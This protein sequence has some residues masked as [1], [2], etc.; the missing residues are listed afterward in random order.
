MRRQNSAWRP[1]LLYVTLAVLAMTCVFVVPPLLERLK[2]RRRDARRAD[3]ARR[4]DAL[5]W[6]LLRR[7]RGRFCDRSRS[8]CG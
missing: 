1:V 8:D 5:R 4:T 6:R 7:N 2:R 3:D